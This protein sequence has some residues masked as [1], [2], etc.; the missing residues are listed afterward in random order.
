[1]TTVWSDCKTDSLLTTRSRPVLDDAVLHRISR[2]RDPA[3]VRDHRG[4][5][6]LAAH[7][8]A[9]LAGVPVHAVHLRQRCSSCGGDGHGRPVVVGLP[10]V[11]VSWSHSRGHVAATASSGAVAVDVERRRDV[12]LWQALSPDERDWVDGQHDRPRAFAR[13]WCR[14]ECVVKLGHASLDHLSDVG[15]VTDGRLTPH[16]DGWVVTERSARD[17]TVVVLSHDLPVRA[18]LPLDAARW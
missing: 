4:A 2:L 8:V 1:M 13:L 3:D 5:R 9:S 15:F 17:S 10:Q 6:I 16:A 12:V 7:C 18:T 11:S 14:K